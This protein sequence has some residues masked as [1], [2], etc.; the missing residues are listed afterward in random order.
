MT[1]VKDDPVFINGKKAV[2][3][4][5]FTFDFLLHNDSPLDLSQ[6]FDDGLGRFSSCF[7]GKN[8]SG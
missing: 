7:H 4:N 2:L 6:G 8:H 3:I 5:G 1:I